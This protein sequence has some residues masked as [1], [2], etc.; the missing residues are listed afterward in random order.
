MKNNGDTLWFFE[1][2]PLSER[3]FYIF[4]YTPQK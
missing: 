1:F 3:Y 2:E 4:S